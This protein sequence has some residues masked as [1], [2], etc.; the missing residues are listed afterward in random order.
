[1]KEKRKKIS[2]LPINLLMSISVYALC[3]VALPI[4]IPTL[5]NWQILC[6]SVFAYL[7]DATLHSNIDY[8]E[9]E[10]D[11]KIEELQQK[12]KDKKN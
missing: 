7:Y 9:Y 11:R 1:M 12:I 2:F 5:T 6:I 10:I 8:V 3:W 4:L